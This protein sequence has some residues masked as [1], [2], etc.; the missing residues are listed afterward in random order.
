MTENSKHSLLH[1]ATTPEKRREI[2]RVM[3][4]YENEGQVD[5]T[6]FG[7]NEEY[8]MVM[9]LLPKKDKPRHYGVICSK[10]PKSKIKGFSLK[11]T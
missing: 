6:V 11:I 2:E 8:Y 1:S 4:H 10:F 7:E 3:K 9:G 5:V